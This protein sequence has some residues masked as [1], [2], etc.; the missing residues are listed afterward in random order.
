MKK[1]I[2]TIIVL[3]VLGGV[4]YYFYNKNKSKKEISNA[5]MVKMQTAVIE[6]GSIKT[7]I[8]ITGEIE[9]ETVVEIKSK[10]SGKILHFKKDINDNV[11]FGDL[12]ATIEADYQ[13]AN[14]ITNTR[15]N[16]SLA[17]IRYEWSVKE[18]EDM[19]V[20][21]E[22]KQETKYNLDLAQKDLDQSKIN[23]D[24]SQEKYNQVEE[25]DTK[26]SESNIF[27]SANGTVISRAVEVGEMVSSITSGNSNGTVIMRIADLSKMIVKSNINEIDINKY[28]EGQKAEI[29]IPANPYNKYEGIITQVAI[30][31]ENV[32]NVKVFP[33]EIEITNVDALIKP[34][35]T[36]EIVI[37]GDSKEDI[38]TIPIKA[39]FSNAKG[40]DIVYIVED[41]KVKEP[42]I[43]KTGLNNFN[44]VEIIK[45]LE[46]GE[47]ISIT[48]PALMGQPRKKKNGRKK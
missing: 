41:G 12:L 37:E 8:D 39:L 47:E 26:G 11:K 3:A 31:A 22:A 48:P 2:I 20:L 18:Y 4:P 5:P 27:S 24:I 28:K 46:V 42:R 1:I 19:L 25:I 32:N 13:Q 44:N 7:Q 23:L 33:I 43:V 10:V 40:E 21:Y 16:L 45:G 36:A 14:S 17:K 30:M 6:L 9:P 38:I 29:T 34:G 15:S 35:M